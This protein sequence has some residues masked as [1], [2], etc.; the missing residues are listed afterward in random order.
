MFIFPS[1]ISR[2]SNITY[3]ITKTF[4]H[5]KLYLFSSVQIKF[6]YNNHQAWIITIS[7]IHDDKKIYREGKYTRIS[8]FQI[9]LHSYITTH[10]WNI[11]GPLTDICKEALK[12]RRGTFLC[13][14][15][16][17][18]QFVGRSSVTPMCCFGIQLQQLA[19]ETKN[20][21]N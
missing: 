2:S 20:D 3:L 8:F 5:F 18:N 9:H 14:T 21:I 4:P 10:Q 11:G 12:G 16:K 17:I 1:D 15:G 13:S 7:I 6:L 19:S